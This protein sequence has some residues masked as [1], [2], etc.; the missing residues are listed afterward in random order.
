[1]SRQP[2]QLDAATFDGWRTYIVGIVNVTPDSFSD[3][4]SYLD[5]G[6]AVAR[7]E[8]LVAQGA[9]WLDVGG[10]STRPG[11]EPVT[12]D[13]ELR[14]VL[15]VLRGLAA[16]VS[17]PLSVDTYKAAVA[18]AALDVGATIVNDVSGG[19]L[20][21]E[22][23]RV[24]AERGGG[25]VLGHLRGTPR[26]MQRNIRFDDV[27]REVGDELA[28]RVGRALEIGV[29]P[30]GLV[31]DPGLGFGK[32]SEQCMALLGAGAALRHRCAAPVMVGPSRKRFLG[33]LSGR[34]VHQRG[35]ETAVACAIA[36]FHG[37][38]FVRVHDVADVAVALR[39]AASVRASATPLTSSSVGG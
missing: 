28:T 5:P 31:V 29:R 26:E 8:E 13:E 20:D 10:E 22:L 3:G 9:H 17:V 23:L 25:L 35:L 2:R 15:P 1:M 18:R 33:E 6:R 37:A 21:P 34:A 7:A 4:G 38:S 12:A 36:A 24:V 14:R 39:L 30:D 27:V 11:A 16:S 32:T 19:A